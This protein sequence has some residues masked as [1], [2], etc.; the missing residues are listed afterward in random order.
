L[1][2]PYIARSRAASSLVICGSP[3]IIMS[4]GS[5]GIRPISTK[6][7]RLIRASVMAVWMARAAR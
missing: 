1:S 4:M 5:P 7:T 3:E 6:T 2:R